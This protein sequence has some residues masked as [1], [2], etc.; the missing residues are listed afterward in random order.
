MRVQAS[1]ADRE[2]YAGAAPVVETGE[3][4]SELSIGDVFLMLERHKW[5]IVACII[6]AMALAGAYIATTVPIYEATASLRIDPS[7]ASS[8]GFSEIIAAGGGGASDELQTEI[9]II[10]SD[11]VAIDTLDSL[12]DDDF[13]AY[14]K[15]SKQSLAF[16]P[17]STTFT[18][19]QE[20]LLG[21]F[22]GSVG[23][24]QI[25]GTQLVGLSFRDPNP[26]LAAVMLNHL[27]ASYLHQSFESR[28]G[29][30]A[31][32]SDWLSGQMD[33][34]KERSAEAQR[35]LATFQEKNNIIG[36]D[37]SNNTVMDRLRLLNQRLAD[38]QANRIVKEAQMR[39]AM[40]GNPAV[41]ASMFA[42]PDLDALESEQGTLYGQYAEMS[43][44]FGPSYPPL[45][46]LKRQMQKVDAEVDRL[47][48]T[49]RLHAKQDYDTAAATEQLLQ[50]QYQAQTAKA[51]DLNRQ[52]AEY[53]IL[54]SESTSTRDLYDTL[55][56]KLQ[57]AGVDAGLNGVNT[58]LVD[59][60]RAPLHPV[61]PKKTLILS[62][63]LILG[64]FAGV[65]S[66]FLREATSDSVQSGEQMESVLGYHLLAMIP[67]NPV[68]DMSA[69][70][71]PPGGGT[72]MP[73][74]LTSYV[75][76]L[77][78]YAESYR[79]LRNSVLLSSLDRP[80]KTILVTS[81][82]AG[83]GKSSCS[84]NLAVVLAQRGARVLAIDADLRRPSL[85]RN[86]NMKNGDGLS[87]LILG[88]DVADPFLRPLVDLPNLVLLTAGKRVPLP[89]EA[90]NSGKFFSLLAQWES[91]YDH[92]LIDSAPLLVVSDSLP[93]ASQVD[94]VVVVARYKN[95][96]LRALKRARSLLSRT[97]AHVAGVVLNDVSAAGT[98]YGGYGYGDY[99]N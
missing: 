38:A 47:I 46:E 72:P 86:F 95:T 17:K 65:G 71:T 30:V 87:N 84:A 49:V 19:A 41:I 55:Q 57:Q 61:E 25:E 4:A 44:K 35:R 37:A 94:A 56:Y 58:M 81:P 31:Q 92:V 13:R 64:L 68:S 51:Y 82:L 3:G 89:S 45:A 78:R 88:E 73:A 10:K 9:A 83:E 33:A 99:Y 23:A 40:T 20:G 76:P 74:M 67:H 97:S 7:R 29:S 6:V 1:P 12:S 75:E 48:G 96:S 54:Q 98:K 70:V 24:K 27:I 32:V 5:F 85:H 21:R 39:A 60:A 14:T 34:L 90:L 63:G 80:F 69:K 26:R 42:N 59:S 62:F 50:D 22:K 8:L 77:S 79:S 15:A 43:A 16:D 11:S 18:P 66:S 53:S 28:Y 36:V 52:Q 2:P 91:E 93:M